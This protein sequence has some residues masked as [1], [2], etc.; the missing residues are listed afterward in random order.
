MTGIAAMTMSIA[1]IA[2]LIL[3]IAGIRFSFGTEHR[4][5]GILMVIAGLVITANVL[6]WTV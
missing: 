6:I 3:L 1:M 2:A 5:Q 4:K